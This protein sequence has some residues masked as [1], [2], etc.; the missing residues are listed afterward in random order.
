MNEEEKVG[1]DEEAVEEEEKAEEEQEETDLER[2]VEFL[3]SGEDF[4]DF[5]EFSSSNG[6]IAPVLEDSGLSQEI[7]DLE[8]NLANVPITEEEGGEVEYQTINMPD[9]GASYD[10]FGDYENTE[11][12]VTDKSNRDIET[13]I[14]RGIT[15]ERFES[16]DIRPLR[17]AQQEAWR[18]QMREQETRR[19][20]EDYITGGLR[21]KKS[22]GKLPHEA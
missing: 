17:Q 14:T 3:D 21:E 8:Q 5:S 11:T 4:Q 12:P 6:V 22:K 7:P 20:R 13:D 1:E 19:M 2:E 15:Q 9:Y 10:S 16:L 18:E